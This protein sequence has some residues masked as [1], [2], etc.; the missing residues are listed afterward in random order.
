M[1]IFRLR[2]GRGRRRRGT[3][4]RRARFARMLS[5]R[6]LWPGMIG[7]ALAVGLGVQMGESTIGS[8]NP[9]HFQGAA[10]PVLAIDPNATPPPSPYA[11]AYGWEHGYAARA[12]DAGSP[13]A[14]ASGYPDFD[15]MPEVR[16]H[17][18]AAPVWDDESAPSANLTP[19]PPGQVSSHPEVERYTDYPVERKPAAA[20]APAAEPRTDAPQ[21]DASALSPPVAPPLVPSGK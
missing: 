2:L 10:P 13:A 18:A 9:V 19:W 3:G 7:I 6:L 11:Q 14:Y 20:P 21:P 1:R 8:I 5:S 4:R 16:V 15:Y 17:R 12:A